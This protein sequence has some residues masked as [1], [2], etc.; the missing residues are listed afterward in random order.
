MCLSRLLFSSFLY[1][2]FSLEGL[3]LC[4]L[5][6]AHFLMFSSVCSL[7]ESCDKQFKSFPVSGSKKTRWTLCV[8]FLQFYSCLFFLVLYSVFLDFLPSVF[9]VFRCSTPRLPV[10]LPG[11]Q[12]HEV[13]DS[14]SESDEKCFSSD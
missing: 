5:E 6:S 3:S 9:F 8:I 12:R 2:E 10:A 14:V 7:V 4:T 11:Y 13:L 1:T